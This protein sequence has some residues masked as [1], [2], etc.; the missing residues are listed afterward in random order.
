MAETPC[1]TGRLVLRAVVCLRD[2]GIDRGY[3]ASDAWSIVNKSKGKHLEG[4]VAKHQ[5]RRGDQTV[6]NERNLSLFATS[7]GFGLGERQE[8]RPRQMMATLT[9]PGRSPPVKTR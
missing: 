9:N 8:W 4:L 1:C 2:G 5:A 7:W 3:L 6:E